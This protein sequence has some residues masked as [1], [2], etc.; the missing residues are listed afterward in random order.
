[1]KKC[2]GSAAT[3]TRA[4]AAI[5]E[6]MGPVPPPQLGEAEEVT[7]EELGER[8]RLDLDRQVEGQ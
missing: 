6:A 5:G 4:A 8:V 2:S 1:M 7:P 3:Q